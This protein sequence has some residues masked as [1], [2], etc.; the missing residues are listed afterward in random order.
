MK[1]IAASSA[2]V[3]FAILLQ[4]P[5]LADNK[6][7]IVPDGDELYQG[8]VLW[9]ENCEGCHGYG[10]A[11]APIPMQ[12]EQW[13]SRIS[14]G[15]AQL[16]EHAINGFVGPDYSFMPARGGNYELSDNQ[17]K[18]AVDYMVFLADFYIKQQ[19]K[20][21]SNNDTTTN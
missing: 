3:L 18:R 21:V 10:I 5:V 11:D 20:E 9:L 12:A 15:K 13:R 1:T 6:T 2:C 8:R 14:K 17:V 16:Y 7:Y 4:P 19:S